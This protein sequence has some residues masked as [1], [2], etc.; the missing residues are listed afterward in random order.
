MSGMS[1]AQA[2]PIYPAD[3]APLDDGP[4]GHFPGIESGDPHSGATLFAANCVSC[5]GAGGAGGFGPRLIGLADKVTPSFF[6]WRVKAPTPPMPDLHL[7]D[8]QIVDLAAYLETLGA[9]THVVGG[10]Q[11]GAASQTGARR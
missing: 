5:H 6:A 3:Q 1:M 11:P 8:R 9:T 4:R 10:A 7:T 2:P